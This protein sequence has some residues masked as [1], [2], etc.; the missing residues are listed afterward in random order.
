[1]ISLQIKNNHDMD[2]W[3]LLVV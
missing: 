1:M 3:K 2:G